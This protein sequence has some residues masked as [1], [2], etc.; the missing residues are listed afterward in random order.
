MST[1][2]LFWYDLET[3]GANVQKDHPVQFAG[4]RTDLELNVIGKPLNLFCQ[5]PSDYLPHPMACMI[6][7]ITPQQSLRDG[8]VEAEFIKRIHQEFSQPNTCVAGYNSL[9]F[10]DE[11][12]RYSFYR[13]FYDPYQR[14]WQQGNS[15]WDIIDMVRACYALRPEGIE[16]P[17]REDGSPSFKLETLTEANNL[18]HQQAHD[19]LSDV[20]ATIALAK[21]IKDKQPKLYQYLFNLRSKQQVQAQ[22]DCFN[23]TPLVHISSKLPASQGCCT[24]IVPVCQHPKNKN[25]VVVLNLML[26]PGP[27]LEWD[28]Q[29]LRE[30]LY[31]PAS[32]LDEGEERLPIKLLHINKCPV[33]APA[34]TLTAENAERLGIDRQK[35]LDNLKL[36]KEAPGLVQKLQEVFEEEAMERQLDADHALYTGGFLSDADRAKCEQI[37]QLAPQQLG[38]REWQFQDPRLNTLLFR[39]R[40]RNYPATL[41]QDELEK[42]QRHRQYRLLDNDSP[43]SIHLEEFLLEIEHLG[44]EHQQDSNKLAI[45]RALY[46]Y[47]KNI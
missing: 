45:L 39:Y 28:A 12:M 29:R 22:I 47:A 21:L 44:Q 5:I 11:V 18:V 31:T 6:T 32:Q 15:R 20:R 25:A 35:C 19:A 38:A 3:W 14:E 42:W 30:R 10:D 24:W 41:N 40:A 17:L 9:R 8:M 26:D 27:L 4:I 2:S 37:R 33:I 7:G 43:A 13:N 46:Q 36:L 1:E 23:M 34:K 16:W